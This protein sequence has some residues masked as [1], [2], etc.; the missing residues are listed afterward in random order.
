MNLDKD[1]NNLVVLD[2]M[3]VESLSDMTLSEKRL[4]YI[5]LSKINPTLLLT[6]SDED[7]YNPKIS[8]E[9]FGTRQVLEGEEVAGKL[10]TLTVKE[11]ATLVGLDLKDAREALTFVAERLYTRSVSSIIGNKFNKF[12]WVQQVIFDKDMDSVSLMWSNPIIPY[13]RQL[14]SYFVQLRLQHLLTLNSS[15]SW[16]LYEVLKMEKGKNI[17][18][19]EVKFEVE[20]L[21]TLL[22]V[23]ESRKEYKFFK[24]KIIKVAVGELITKNVMPQ[25]DYKEKKVG[26]RIVSLEFVW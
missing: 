15:Y 6:P 14:T 25:L 1:L 2:N 11:Y 12:R 16:R 22:N 24:S 3:L 13:I 5:L 21:Q 19:K 26:R 8:V 17:Y 20:E 10:F 23:P 9:E 4:I 7:I 18:K